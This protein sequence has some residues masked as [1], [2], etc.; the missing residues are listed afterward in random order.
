MVDHLATCNL[1]ITLCCL[2]STTLAGMQLADGRYL[3]ADLVVDCSGRMS[4]M[5]DWLHTAGY[6]K[7]R[8]SHVT[9]NCGYASWVA[10]LSSEAEQKLQGLNLMYFTAQAPEPHLAMLQRLEDGSWMICVGAYQGLYPPLQDSELPAYIQR[11]VWHPAYSQLIAGST[12]LTPSSRFY[13][14]SNIWRHY[15][16]IPLPENLVI[17]ADSVCS[18]NPVYGQGM[19][20]AAMEAIALDSLLSRRNM[21]ATPAAATA[22]AD[23]PHSTRSSSIG[24]SRYNNLQGLS[25]EFQHAALTV[26]QPAWDLATGME[27]KFAG[28]K[29]NEPKPFMAAFIAGY[30]DVVF[31]LAAKDMVVRCCLDFACLLV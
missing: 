12:A 9:A 30:T 22:L 26:L 7:P 23:N 4:H 27:R 20:V 29:S 8:V 11:D 10:K 18:F 31:E 17:M 25:E 5:T 3:A 2:P 13:G 24:T 28:A 19:A 21:T 14:T 16:E 1:M 6:P 15:E